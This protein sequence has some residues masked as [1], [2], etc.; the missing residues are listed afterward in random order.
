M[1]L[2]QLGCGFCLHHGPLVVIWFDA[3]DEVRLAGGQR[4]HQ[5]VERLTELA[6]KGRDTFLAVLH[7]MRAGRIKKNKQKNSSQAVELIEGRVK[8]AAREQH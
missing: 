4:F 8:V 2:L 3:A 6:D 1:V 5:G 7:L